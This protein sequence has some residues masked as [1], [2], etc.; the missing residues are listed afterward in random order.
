MG[1]A[2]IDGA[3]TMRRMMEQGFT[4]KGLAE[5]AGLSV[6]TVGQ[7]ISEKNNR[8]PNLRTAGKLARALG[9][10]PMELLKA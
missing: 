7:V 5:A 1:L 3:K 10:D 6:S 8:R 2:K 9:C 4:V